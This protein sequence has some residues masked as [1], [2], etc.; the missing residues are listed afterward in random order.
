MRKTDNFATVPIV[1]PGTRL[2]REW[3]GVIHEVL[4]MDEG[5]IYRGQRYSS[6]TAVA[7]AITGSKQSGPLFFGLYRRR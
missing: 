2:I 5:V 7:R 6:L 3:H 4:V 1:K